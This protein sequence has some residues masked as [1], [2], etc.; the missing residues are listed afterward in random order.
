MKNPNEK[1]QT[2][3]LGHGPISHFS[4]K[5][6]SKI[7]LAMHDVKSVLRQVQFQKNKNIK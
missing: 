3:L 6:F 2:H 5:L 4:K 1:K 7:C